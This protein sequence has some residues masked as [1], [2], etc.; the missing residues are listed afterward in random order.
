MNAKTRIATADWSTINLERLHKLPAVKLPPTYRLQGDMGNGCAGD[1]PGYPSYFTRSV[2]TG[3]GDNPSRGAVTVI[4][5]H[6]VETAEFGSWDK[7]EARLR[8]L[9]VP[10]PLEHPRTQ[11][12]IVSTFRHHRHCYHVPGAE[13]LNFHDDK[14]MLIWPG[15]CLDKTPFGTLKDMDGEIKWATEHES[16]GKWRDEEKEA[17]KAAIVTNNARITRECEAIATPENA[18]ATIIVRRYYPEFTPTPDLFSADL[19]APGNWWEVMAEC[20]TPETCHGQYGTA[21]PVNT[22]WC[23]MCGWHAPEPAA[24]ATYPGS[25]K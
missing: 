7:R 23:Q 21:H 6:V 25:Q 10:L 5:G 8:R 20:P 11:A 16:F 12:W 13:S 17:F 19:E 9:W 1:P 14:R 4:G 3:T 18:T 2:Y 15:G 24:P 22:S